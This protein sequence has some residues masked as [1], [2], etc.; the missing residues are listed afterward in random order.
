MAAET[1]VN[2]VLNAFE[3]AVVEHG[4]HASFAQIARAGGFHRSLI[5]H[6]FKTRERLLEAAIDRVVAYY[7]GRLDEHH[8]V[9]ALLGW[10]FAPFPASG[11]PRV[12]KVVDAFQAL[13][14]SSPYVRGRLAELYILFGARL[15]G[16]LVS[17]RAMPIGRARTV[18]MQVVA[19]SFG[20]AGLDT[21]GLEVDARSAAE[22]LLADGA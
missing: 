13:A 17:E 19:L 14:P 2:R 9:D 15:A 18:S 5:Q 10:Y 22:A 1:P 6:H 3:D 20:R 16:A 7:S 11:P 21:L 4:V 8:G 12:A